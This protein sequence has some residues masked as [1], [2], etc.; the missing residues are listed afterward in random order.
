MRL[1]TLAEF[2]QKYKEYQ[3][4]DIPSYKV[5][6]AS[7]M[8]FS[9]IGLRYR[10]I[11]WTTSNV[12][13]PIKEACMEQLRFMLDHDIPTLDFKGKIK[14][15]SMEAELVSDISSLSLRILGNNGYLYRGNAIN[16]NM[17]LNIPFGG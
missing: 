16:Q 9:Q 15:G 7:E 8:I 6:E 10:D 11:S 1:F 3:T 17:G 5:D 13:L 4:L 2:Q 12:P 14:A